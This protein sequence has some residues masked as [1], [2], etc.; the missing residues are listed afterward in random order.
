MEGPVVVTEIQIVRCSWVGNHALAQHYHDHVWGRKPV[1]DR[2]YFE[3]LCIEIF[4]AGLNFKLVL[5]KL[6]H[7]RMQ[8]R[9]FDPAK[10]ARM[11]DVSV[12]KILAD[13]GGI[14]SRV[15]TESV[16]HNAGV[17]LELARQ[18]GSFGK[19]VE[20]VST[21]QK[22]NAEAEFKKLFK[23]TGPTIV[24]EFLTSTGHW[25]VPHEKGC[26]LAGGRT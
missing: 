2:G 16:I 22:L 24:Y 3:A 12:D 7:L 17:V 14:R 20:R 19:W 21:R 4:E 18:Y 11:R 5:G 13:A 6:S 23:F 25:P 15:K 10:I 8:Y 9:G 1:D 26:F